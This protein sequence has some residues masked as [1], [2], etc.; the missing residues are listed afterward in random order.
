MVRYKLKQGYVAEG[1]FRTASMQRTNTYYESESR[2]RDMQTGGRYKRLGVANARELQTGG[3]CKR[4][5]VAKAQGRRD[6]LQTRRGGLSL[7]TRLTRSDGS[8]LLE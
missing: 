2:G 8:Y 5:G 7:S 6:S 3:G 1:A 4:A